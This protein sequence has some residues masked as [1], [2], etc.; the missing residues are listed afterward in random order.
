MWWTKSANLLLKYKLTPRK[1]KN[2]ESW[3]DVSDKDL[4]TRK[5]FVSGRLSSSRPTIFYEL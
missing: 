5:G 1:F 3:F 2:S 4:M